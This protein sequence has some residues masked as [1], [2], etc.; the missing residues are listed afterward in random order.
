MMEKLDWNY[1]CPFNHFGENKACSEVE[2]FSEYSQC[3]TYQKYLKAKG[4]EEEGEV[5]RL[6][7][8]VEDK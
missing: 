5:S 1:E 2:C 4:E 8:I 3:P 6:L 7:G